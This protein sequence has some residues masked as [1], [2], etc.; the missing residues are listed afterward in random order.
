LNRG[1]AAALF[2]VRTLK[3]DLKLKKLESNE[4]ST[5][6]TH[7]KLHEILVDIYMNNR[8]VFREA[9]SKT[10]YNVPTT[11]SVAIQTEKIKPFF[12]LFQKVSDRALQE[13]VPEFNLIRLTPGQELYKEGEAS[14]SFVYLVISG[15]LHLFHKRQKIGALCGSDSVGEEVIV[16]DPYLKAD[17]RQETVRADTECFLFEFDTVKWKIIQQKLKAAGL[18]IDMFTLSN[19]FKSQAV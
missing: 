7:S 11:T 6:T 13:I 3:N 17:H 2:N 9:Q 18:D 15:Y 10:D 1:A 5:R 16:A 4:V 19:F 8:P 14:A 12:M